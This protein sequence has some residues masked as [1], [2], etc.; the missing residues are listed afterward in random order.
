MEPYSWFDNII[1]ADRD[2]VNWFEWHILRGP[3]DFLDDCR[4]WWN[5]NIARWPRLVKMAY[6]RVTRGHDDDAVWNMNSW[7]IQNAIPIL[8]KWRNDGIS[9]PCEF[10]C[11]EE[12]EIVLDKMSNGFQHYYDCEMGDGKVDDVDRGLHMEQISFSDEP[13]EAYETCTRFEMT[14]QEEAEFQEA[15][16]LFTKYFYTLWD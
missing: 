11:R 5:R 1:Y 8:N 16:N 12:W 13:K 3:F 7:F 2:D 15:L 10:H 14:P 9:F 4:C 6:Q